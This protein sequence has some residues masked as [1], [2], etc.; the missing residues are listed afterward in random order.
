MG[1]GE[2]RE[3]LLFQSP[4]AADDGLGNYTEGWQDE[5]TIWAR[6]QPRVGG[7]TILASR[8]AGRQVY[9]IRVRYSAEALRIVPD[10]QAVHGDGRAFQIKSPVRNVDE[11]K[12]YLE[13]DAEF[14]VAA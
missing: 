1:A 9:L 8:L 5:F 4:A 12:A 6:L 14:G 3:R 7:E 13:M 11:K 2:L 10:W